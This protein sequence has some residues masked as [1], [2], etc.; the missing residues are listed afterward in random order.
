MQATIT[1][2]LTEQAQRTQ[3]AATGQPVARKQTVTVEVSGE[4][5]ALMDVDA[6]GQPFLDLTWPHRH[7]TD[8]LA[9]GAEDGEFIGTGLALDKRPGG[10][11]SLIP[12]ADVDILA[13][14]R[15]GRANLAAKTQAERD[16]IDSAMSAFLASDAPITD[17]YYIYHPPGIS[18]DIRDWKDDLAV[19]FRA[20][21]ER[22]FV[23]HETQVAADRAAQAAERKRVEDEK[24]ATEAAKEQAKTDFI[25]QW[26]AALNPA[27]NLMVAS[28]G[29]EHPDGLWA[30][31]ALLKQQFADGLLCR[32]TVI[33]LIAD[34][35]F[36]AAG[37]PEAAEWDDDYCDS[38]TC[39]CGSK[40]LDCLPTAQYKT[41]KLIAPKLP[42]GYTVELSRVR[43]C[44]RQ[45]S[46]GEVE[47]ADA[48]RYL[49]E[50]KLPYGPF[51]F[52]RTIEL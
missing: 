43:E 34:A 32:K 29:A 28:A 4:D 52:E 24:A 40:M 41:W 12:S 26:I 42:D 33:G 27:K 16:K 31:M 25:A 3:M 13:M 47:T 17:R 10:Y 30:D 45:A 8:L 22:R 38:N 39:P 5:L 48:P 50:I 14:I 19:Q 49:A 23:V 36:A 20:E 35:A 6:E 7:R 2:L 11:P 18:T 44:R 37:V 1:Y 21:A 46:E 9:A 51:V 15:K